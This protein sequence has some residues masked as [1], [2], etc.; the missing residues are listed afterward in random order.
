MV[1]FSV[2]GLAQKS[3]ID[4]NTLKTF[5]TMGKQQLV[6]KPDLEVD[7]FIYTGKGC[8][9]HMWFG[10]AFN[11]YGQTRLRVYVDGEAVP[12]IDMELFLGHGIGF[13]DESAP[14]G[15]VRLGN[16]GG[17]S[18]IYNTYRIPFGKSVRVTAQLANGADTGQPFWWIIRGT[19]NLP[20][21]IAG[22]R[23]PDNAHLKLY[24][25]E[26]YTAKPFEEFSMCNV[27]VSGA[28]Y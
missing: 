15:V 7:L 4:F 28:W 17:N 22:V 13:D 3:Q 9:T 6:L 27:S 14:W 10:G 25:L 20:V 19:E 26:K 5:G 24:K 21:E 12:D 8:L 2:P 23:L 1:L 18:G 16:N 11:G